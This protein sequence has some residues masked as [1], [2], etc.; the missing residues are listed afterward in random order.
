M[1]AIAVVG[2]VCGL[3]LA[4]SV[5]SPVQAYRSYAS[6][7]A[8]LDAQTGVPVVTLS[9]AEAEDMAARKA[10]CPFIGSLVSSQT[11]R[12]YQSAASPLASIGD[13]KAAGNTGP[14]STLGLVLELFAIGNHARQAGALP[15]RLD[16]PVPGGMFALDFPG[17]QGAHWGHSG[18]LVGN[19]T[20]VGSGRW[21]AADFDRLMAKADS[22]GLLSTGAVGQFIAQNI[23]RDL[24]SKVLETGVIGLLVTDSAKLLRGL[25]AT[26]T[27][28]V[29]GKIKPENIRQVAV[30]FTKVRT[31]IAVAHER[32]VHEAG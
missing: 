5:P 8:T 18:I 24:N 27:A 28:L 25:G 9:A 17:S 7:G 29:S 21:S 12:V 14:G 32:P 13:V 1:R 6:G 10:A 23:R 11:L 16:A 26:V 19:P 15:A 3:C 31:R 20:V 30:D 22:K 2:L 4:L